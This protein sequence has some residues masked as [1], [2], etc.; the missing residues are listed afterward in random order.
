MQTVL[1][2]AKSSIAE[3]ISY[4][5]EHF[6]EFDVFELRLDFLDDLDD[7]SGFEIGKPVILTLR[8]KSEGGRFTGDYRRALLKLAELDSAYLDVESWVGREFI[9]SLRQF[10]SGKII[11]SKHLDY[12]P[13]D[14]SGYLVDYFDIYKLVV[15]SGSSIDS[16]RLMH[17]AKEHPGLVIHSTGE[18]GVVTR[19]FGI[20]QAQPLIFIGG[21]DYVSR[22]EMLDLYRIKRLNPATKILGLIGMPISH[23][24]GCS[25]H[26]SRLLVNAVYVNLPLNACELPEFFR[27]IEGLP[28]EGFSVTTP[29]KRAVCEHVKTSFLAVNTIVRS[30]GWLG[31]NTDGLGVMQ[32]LGT[33]VSRVLVI[34]VGGAGIAVI[35]QL[36]QA[37][38]PYV[39]LNRTLEHASSFGQAYDYYSFADISHETFDAIINTTP[40]TNENIALLENLLQSCTNAST[41]YLSLDYKNQLQIKLPLKV[42]SP[43]TMFEAQA[44]LQLEIFHKLSFMLK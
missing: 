14:F 6:S 11:G 31:Y 35:E 8:T 18:Y 40:N 32:A 26:N 19:I 24:L 20:I 1:V 10:Y 37:Q 25:Y 42:I 17:F 13:K 29:L 28:F 15:R 22:A 3:S 44:K 38:V 41:K 33:D 39:V 23:S 36:K 2:V 5:Q 16:L 4:C 7:F 27:L 34:G 12:S 21:D 30:G 9:D 43:I